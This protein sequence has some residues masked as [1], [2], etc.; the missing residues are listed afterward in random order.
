MSAPLTW[1]A[2]EPITSVEDARARA[3][4][5]AEALEGLGAAETW[6]GRRSSYADA[7]A[8]GESDGL[9]SWFAPA[10]IAPAIKGRWLLSSCGLVRRRIEAALGIDHDGL[11]PPYR[12]GSCM[13]V[14]QAAAHEHGAWSHPSDLDELGLGDALWRADHAHVCT[15]VALDLG[16]GTVATVDGGQGGGLGE[17]T[18][19]A[20]RRRLL[21]RRAGRV[22]VVDAATPQAA[23][24]PLL[25][26]TSL[27]WSRA[28][29]PSQAAWR[30]D[31][32]A[33]A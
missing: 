15:V 24:W 10:A 27:A 26:F 5:V 22:Y 18:E 14:L 16:A 11:L 19:I 29:R 6:H 4:A 32:S 8:L 25:A 31:P 33:A 20:R 12:D 28:G 17:G 7:V 1:T 23:G 30:V 21:V 9:R 3:V 2:E 13:A